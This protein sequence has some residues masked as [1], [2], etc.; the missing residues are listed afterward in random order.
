MVYLRHWQQHDDAH[1]RDRAYQLLRTVT[2]LQTADGPDAGNVVL[3]MQPDGTLNPSPEPVELPDPS[4]S[5]ESYW[6]ARTIWALGEGYA[7]FAE[8]DPAFATFLADR[9]DLALGAV[10][11]QSLAQYGSWE[12]SDGARVPAWLI[13]DGADA[14]A[15]AMLGLAAYVEAG[16]R[17]RAALQRASTA[18]A[19]Y[20]EGVAAMSAGNS[21]S[22]PY[23]A[24]LPWTHS[25]SLWH[26]WASQMPAALAAS[27]SVLERPQLLASAVRD[28]GTFTPYLLTATGAVNGW[29]PVPA[30]RTQIAYGVDSRLRS[31][32]AVADASDAPGFEQLVPLTASWYFGA[33]AAG[34]QMYDPE[35]GRTFDG[36][37][38]DGVVN[39]NSG[40]ESTIHGQLSMLALDQR[41]DLAAA[42]QRLTSQD[43]Q[44]G[45][46]V[47]EAEAGEVDG[48]GRVVTPDPGWTGESGWSGS[49]LELDPGATAR[50]TVP[51]ADGPRLV[52]A[53]V[54]R[55]DTRRATELRWTSAGRQL[56]SV[57]TGRAGAQ[58]VSEAP[59]ALLPVTLR[60][61]LPGSA[62]VLQVDAVGEGRPPARLDALLLRPVVSRL[63]LSGADAGATLLSN[64]S[65]EVQRRMVESAPGDDSVVR[66]YRADG[67]LWYADEASEA[68][69]EVRLAPGGFA[70]VTR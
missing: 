44:D 66:S 2:Y 35:T 23:G 68:E 22:Y 18:L 9:L 52:A 16:G 51:E 41:P 28:S 50:W 37:N 32:L 47:V 53:V 43:G 31:L 56:G 34:E 55:R 14:T 15:E 57:D 60:E 62:G 29:L 25:R 30:D 3:W 64:A 69:V 20:A 49:A 61:E 65:R 33:N 42:A 10:E 1:S 63:A 59:G 7:A 48:P 39:H 17:D 12:V 67:R 6:L 40:A 58:G 54:D 45:V 36:L 26:A 46:T 24:I 4:D 38:G 13:V 70:T 27:A 21:R 5:A 8:D 11:R 19:K